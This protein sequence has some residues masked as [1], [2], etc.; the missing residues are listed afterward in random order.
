MGGGLG[1]GDGD[2]WADSRAPREKS[3][4]TQEKAGKKQ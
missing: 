1:R 4:L 2:S 3:R